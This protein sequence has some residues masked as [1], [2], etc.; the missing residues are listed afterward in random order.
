MDLRGRDSERQAIE[1][2]LT[3]A[4]AGRSGALV[5]CGEA[6]IGKTSLLEHA[7]IV[8]ERSQ[9]RVEGAVGMESERHF[10]FAGLHQLCAPL[11]GFADAL[12]EPQRAALGVAL[13]RRSGAVPERFLVGLA[14]LNLLA[15]SAEERPL[16]CIVDDAQWLDPA[17]A[18][19]IAF[20]ARRLEAERV[21][22]VI[23]ARGGDDGE[24]SAFSGI[25][26]V[27]LTGL[28][29]ADARAVFAAAVR[30]PPDDV[31]TDRVIAEARGN[32]LAL[33]ELPRTAR[34]AQLASGFELPE[35]PSIPRRVEESFRR[36]SAE[37]PEDTQRLL[38]VAAAEPTGDAT[39][40]WRAASRLGIDSEAAAAAEA[41]GL[42]TIDATVRFRHPLV[43]SAL[44]GVADPA[45][46]RRA[47]DSLAAAIDVRADPDRRA[48]HRGQAVLGTDEDVAA[49][50][51]QAA[52]R[53]LARGGMA[54]AAAFLHRAAELTPDVGQRTSRAM[55]AAAAKHEAGAPED[56]LK[57]LAIAASGP[58]DDR[59]AARVKLYRAMIHFY[60]TQD[61]DVPAKFLD[62]AQALRPLDR[63]MS[64]ETYLLALNASIITGGDQPGS[65]VRAVADA[66]RA[67]P[68]PTEPPRPLDLLLDGLVT[69]YTDGF[70]AGV[71]DLRVALTAFCAEGLN[72]QV[73]G[74]ADSDRWLWLASRTAVALFD[75][76]LMLDLAA[77]NVRIARRAGALAT[78]HAALVAM[79]SAQVLTGDF[80]QATQLSAEA[81]EIARATGA[82]PLPYAQLFLAAWQGRADETSELVDAS[83]RTAGTGNGAQITLARYATAVLHNGAGSYAA[84][85]DAA[86]RACG[87]DELA[88]GS[89]ALPELVEA[90][91]RSGQPER[92]A[93]ACD[94]LSTRAHASG[95]PWALG[96]AALAHA[97]VG[98]D[99]DAEDHYREAI[100]RLSASRMT[101]HLARAHL[102]YGEWLRREGRRLDA[103]EQ[104][105]TAHD[106]LS[107]MG[108]TGFAE[109]AARELRATGEH[110]RPRGDRPDATL[111]DHE[112][113]IA[114]LVAT[115]ATSRE[116]AG[117]LFL[118]PRTI[119]AHLRSIYRKLGITSRRQ[120]R[121]ARLPTT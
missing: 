24:A 112:L 57:L 51:E 78:L 121:E 60:L 56:A 65:D 92:A 48:W 80:A 25:P 3:E 68:A 72:A 113:H 99:A 12:V 94:Q 88:V 114:R 55:A 8:A 104:L 17:S 111:T 98:P 75:D 53:S 67:A 40:L 115:G 41:A 18:E 33:L 96:Q 93:V 69:T 82:V 30:T 38:L 52:E 29:D 64:R 50:L 84:A 97:L 6:G 63:A 23:A 71:G 31:V 86:S 79:A 73:P 117:Q 46:R 119:D 14:T 11:L 91:A 105:R 59:Q 83:A 10:A 47:H 16:L 7:R 76:D 15:E 42:I 49:E 81:T 107:E 85:L 43:R 20:V 34:P 22:F 89:L 108:A 116:V 35:A 5:L 100:E 101:G 77:R 90:A 110:P 36:R 28:G 37:L 27:T 1:R 13:G 58:L 61:G 106:T 19:V 118:S 95:T 120:L 39:L 2:L 109:R 87:S 103:R 102:V 54:A 74:A 26:S 21:A 62:A 70:A 32:P 45:A 44:Y 66:A 4:R 9:V